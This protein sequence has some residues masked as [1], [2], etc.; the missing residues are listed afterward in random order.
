M[1]LLGGWGPTA[2]GKGT[3]QSDNYLWK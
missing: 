3:P 2:Y 1:G